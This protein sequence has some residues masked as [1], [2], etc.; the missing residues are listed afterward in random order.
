MLI[1]FSVDGPAFK[2]DI[3]GRVLTPEFEVES[4]IYCLEVNYQTK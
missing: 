1:S 4:Y 2:P 3:E